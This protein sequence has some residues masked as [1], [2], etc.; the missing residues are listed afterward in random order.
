MTV[1]SDDELVWTLSS[2]V[3]RRIVAI[4]VSGILEAL[5]DILAFSHQIDEGRAIFLL[6]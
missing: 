2:A 1:G 5:K 3:N 6:P 4:E